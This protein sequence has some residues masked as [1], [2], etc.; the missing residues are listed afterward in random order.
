MIDGA[1]TLKKF[2]RRKERIV[3]E[4]ANSTMAPIVVEPGRDVQVVG[5]LIGV[6][7]RV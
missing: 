3:L 6:V 5:V 1:A 7:R 2:Y 4:P